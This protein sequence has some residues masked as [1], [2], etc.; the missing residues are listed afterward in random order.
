MADEYTVHWKREYPFFYGAATLYG[1]RDCFKDELG[2]PVLIRGEFVDGWLTTFS[3]KGM[4]KRLDKHL[5]HIIENNPAYIEKEIE[6][7]KKAGQE[8]ISFSRNLKI[9]SDMFDKELFRLYQRYYEIYVQFCKNL[10][11]S[12]N[13][14]DLAAT[15]FEKALQRELPLEKVPEAIEILSKPTQ[16]SAIML[17][18]DYFRQEKDAEKRVNYILREFPW[19]GSRDPF[20]EPWTRKDALDYVN[21]FKIAEKKEKGAIEI[22]NQIILKIYQEMLYIKDKRDELRREAFYYSLP[23]VREIARRLGLSLKELSY[24]LPHEIN[25]ENLKEKI[26]KRKEGCIAEL[27]GETFTI[28]EGKEALQHLV[29]KKDV[30]DVN[31]VKGAI[32]AKGVVKG[33]VQLISC[34]KDIVHFK[35]GNILVSITTDPDYVLAME[36]AAAF[37]TDEGGILCHAAILAREMNKPC[38]VGTTIATSVFKDGDLVEVDA[39]NGVVRKI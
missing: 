27:I 32:G 18:S 19:L 4:S 15:A 37:V 36:K 38:I 33:K 25:Q 39:D 30:S 24:L 28:K 5:L 16:K 12:F 6:D 22:N 31:H 20:I 11:K 34:N 26:A 9:T 2:V 8:F 3:Q 13:L 17:I 1:L 23:L 7:L 10:W 29:S 21:S 35:E 14:V